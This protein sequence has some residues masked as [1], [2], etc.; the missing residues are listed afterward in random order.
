[1]QLLASAQ[2]IVESTGSALC[3]SLGYQDG[4]GTCLRCRTGLTCVDSC[5]AGLVC[6][7]AAADFVVAAADRVVAA[8]DCVAA[9]A[10]YV[11]VG[12]TLDQ[13]QQPGWASDSIGR[14]DTGS[15]EAD[16]GRLPAAVA[17]VVD[18]HKYAASPVGQDSGS[19]AYPRILVADSSWDAP[20]CGIPLG[21][22][23]W[24]SRS[25]AER[26]GSQREGFAC[27]DVADYGKNWDWG[28]HSLAA[29][30]ATSSD[31]YQG[32]PAD[33]CSFAGNADASGVAASSR[34]SFAELVSGIDGRV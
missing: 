19:P 31:C 29:A 28:L 34:C 14:F 7:V 27:R 22:S 17:A 16:S 21:W 8:A 33:S 5:A 10:G 26:K 11:V 32:I 4:F 1:M 24:D 9:V 12:C 15:G 20:D 23:M 2:Q 30:A 18:L 6:V 3:C 13:V 25:P